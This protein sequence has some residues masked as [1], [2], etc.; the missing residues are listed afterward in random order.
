MRMHESFQSASELHLVLELCGSP[1]SP[2]HAVK[3]AWHINSYSC[4]LVELRQG[5]GGE[6]YALL[7]KKIKEEQQ[8]MFA[9]AQM[10][11]PYFYL[12]MERGKVLMQWSFNISKPFAEA[13]QS[14]KGLVPG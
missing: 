5:E 11:L 12:E 6:L 10:Q 4:L 7:V 8:A 14:T 2:Q 1:G 3:A 9:M 13:F